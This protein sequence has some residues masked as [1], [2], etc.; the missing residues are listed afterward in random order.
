MD[1]L[2]QAR[3]NNLGHLS[4][5]NEGNICS[6]QALLGIHFPSLENVAIVSAPSHPA[7]PSAG[8]VDF[9]KSSV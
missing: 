1:E 7:P 5:L 4:N 2:S 6:K 9:W 3:P 8:G